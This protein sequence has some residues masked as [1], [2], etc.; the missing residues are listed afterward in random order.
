[1][2]IELYL[3]I[4]LIADL[5][6]FGAVCR[7]LGLFNRRRIPL[8][9]VFS[10]AYAVLAAARPTPWASPAAQIAL[11]AVVARIL[12]GSAALR[13]WGATGLAIA[14]AALLCG[15]LAG[16]AH[17]SGLSAMPLC[18]AAGLLLSTPLCAA[19]APARA[20][21]QVWL[22]LSV[23]K[24]TAR[25]PALID[26]GNRLREPLSGLPVLIAEASLLADVLPEGGYRILRFGAVGG[27]GRMACFKPSA[28]WIERG[29]RR[30]RAPEIWVAASPDP[31]P[32]LYRALAPPEF[33]HYR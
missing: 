5:A 20:G 18:V 16:A 3:A 2:C 17:L 11:I 8:A 15:G 9:A 22:S 4:N 19:K 30:R 6:L 25:F 1:M 24:R 10:A 28:V 26:T 21:W 7:A 33:A 31:L 14:A 12:V 32:G 27:E 23:G 29:G 13:F